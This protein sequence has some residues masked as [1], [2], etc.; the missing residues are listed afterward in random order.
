MPIPNHQLKEKQNLRKEVNRSARHE[1]RSD[2]SLRLE[3][4]GI[5]RKRSATYPLKTRAPGDRR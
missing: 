5:T 1:A 4:K 3:T 2:F